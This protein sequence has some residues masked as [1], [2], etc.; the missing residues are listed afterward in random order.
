MT[1]QLLTKCPHCGTTFRLSQEHLEIAGGAVRCGSCYQVFHAKEHI[2]KTS[3]I[4]EIRRE[5][6]REEPPD[7]FEEFDLDDGD[8]Y[9]EA[10]NWS[11][12]E[13]PDADLF[14]ENYV[15]EDEAETLKEFGLDPEPEPAPKKKKDKHEVDESWA[16]AM[17]E[18]LGE[19]EDEDPEG[20]IQDDPDAD[21]DFASNTGFGSITSSGSAF[22]DEFAGKDD[23]DEISD[24]FRD[25]HYERF[26]KFGV[27]DNADEPTG[28]NT[29]ESWAQ[30]MLEELEAEE[31][32]RPPSL[33]ELSILD[34]SEPEK[35]K[36][37]NPFAAKEVSRSAK[38]AITQAREKAREEA[39]RQ[40][41]QER[42]Q[43]KKPAKTTKAPA[44]DSF[45]GTLT[46]DIDLGDDSFDLGDMEGMAADQDPSR[47]HHTS[48]A[49]EIPRQTD[50]L[51]EQLAVSELHFGDE[52]RKPR[53]GL[54]A[55]ALVLL[56]IIALGGL[57]AQHAYFNFDELARQESYRPYYK[58]ACDYLGCELP[59]RVDISKIQGTNLVVRSHPMEPDALVI[60]AIVYN[61]ANYAQP[62][63]D[64]KLA[65]QD[66]NGKPIA[67]RRFT[68]SEYIQDKQI[69]FQKMPPNTPVHLTLEIVDPGKSAVNYQI[70]FLAQSG[71]K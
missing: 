18:E 67:S 10:P 17:L 57:A 66:I 1:E 21:N 27:D 58:M 69:D 35:E 26:N 52:P 12:D 40:R 41:E 16:E 64:L 9:E 45:F 46:E 63:P 48:T 19:D 31:A 29:D 50:I 42:K 23:E 51:E 25:L 43:G 68:P 30:K 6:A 15:T 28:K 22:E 59:T 36:S 44:E 61:R 60:D 54:K 4:E 49:T 34:D 65:F 8:P 62:Y 32:P 56:N 39:K 14:E 53:S 55:A 20:L 33:E 24:T 70:D 38:D 5:P 7:P 11:A 71:T 37:S 3:V 13:H 47:S 2:V